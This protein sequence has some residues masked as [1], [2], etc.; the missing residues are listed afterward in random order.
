M[1]PLTGSTGQVM[2]DT[3]FDIICEYESE[4]SVSA[5]LVDNTAANTGY[6]N[7]LVVNLEKLLGKNLHTIGC[8]LH[9]NELP[10]RAVFKAL[11]RVSTGPTSFSGPLGKLCN[12]DIHL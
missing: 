9:Q 12:E 11:D 3:S 6:L 7:G 10:L 5:I 2:A 4:S 1:V 8:S